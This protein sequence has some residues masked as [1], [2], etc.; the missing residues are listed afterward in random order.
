MKS[1]LLYFS[2]PHYNRILL[3]MG[4]QSF[5]CH[6]LSLFIWS[7]W[8]ATYPLIA[9]EAEGDWPLLPL[10][11]IQ[12]GD[13]GTVHT[14]FVGTNIETFNAEVV[15]ILENFIAPGRHLILCRLPDAKTWNSG[16]V[17]GMSGSPL[18]INGKLAGALSYGLQVF[19]TER[20][21]GFTPISDMVALN[22]YETPAATTPHSAPLSVHI[23]SDGLDVSGLKPLKAPLHVSG[24]S[25]STLNLLRP[26][27]ESNGLEILQGAGGGNPDKYVNTPFLP[28]SAMALV[29]SQG[30][31]SLAATGTMTYRKNNVIFGFGHPMFNMGPVNLPMARAE[32]VATLPS[33]YRSIKVANSR[34]LIGR[35]TQDRLSAVRGE[36][37]E[38]APMIPVEVRLQYA[39]LPAHTVKSRIASHPRLTPLLA[40]MNISAATFDNLDFPD[41]FTLTSRVRVQLQDQPELI[42]NDIYSGDG[43]DRQAF[44]ADTARWL[45]S[46]YGNSHESPSLQSIVYE[47]QI[48]PLRQTC[49]LDEV[50]VTR[51]KF[52]PGESIDLTFWT[53]PWR[54]AKTRHSLK[55][56]IPEEIKSGQIILEIADAPTVNENMRSRIMMFLNAPGTPGESSLRTT[57]LF[58]RGERPKSITQIVGLLNQ[59]VPS[60]AYYVRLLRKSPGITVDDK[61][62]ENIPSSILSV[63]QDPTRKDDSSSLAENEIW[64]NIIPVNAQASG[65]TRIGITI[66]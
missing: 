64:R 5:R 39:S 37:G 32:I 58:A 12:K 57:P 49:Q 10:H 29:L 56:P 41:E 18:V 8:L 22:D 19:E 31:V 1:A 36:L 30:D 17:A 11:E 26:Y 4:L 65:T 20:Y 7:L 48:D 47:I 60:N 51:T 61:P 28:G 34:Q 62:S 40:L 23:D 43:H 55:I 25:D 45:L 6:F 44:V 3:F 59:Y 15:G 53:R 16:A 35:I 63:M 54:G 27:L 14:V 46:L 38:P 42:M 24:V 33:L 21:A 52:K 50:S 2:R 13:R 66:E 9:S